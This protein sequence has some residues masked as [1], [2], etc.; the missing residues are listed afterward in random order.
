MVKGIYPRD[1]S[2]EPIRARDAI[3]NPIA[4]RAPIVSARLF[5]GFHFSLHPS[6]ILLKHHFFYNVLKYAFVAY[7][8]YVFSGKDVSA[9]DFLAAEMVR[10]LSYFIAFFDGGFD[11][12]FIVTLRSIP[13]RSAPV[14]SMYA[15]VSF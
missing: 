4:S 5:R 13:D 7:L 15:K 3:C 11:I 6:G 10:G 9:S 1:L 8:F 12:F 2:F 14:V